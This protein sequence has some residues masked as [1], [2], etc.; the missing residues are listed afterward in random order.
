MN[1]EYQLRAH[2]VSLLAEIYLDH[3]DRERKPEEQRKKPNLEI[4]TSNNDY[5]EDYNSKLAEI[6]QVLI[7]KEEA[8]FEI[9]DGL[10][11]LCNSPCNRQ[12]SKCKVT[13]HD[14]RDEDHYSYREYGFSKDSKYITKELLGIIE[15]YESRTG[16][17]TPRRKRS[18]QLLSNFAL[19]F[20]LV[21]HLNIYFGRQND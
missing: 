14:D 13:L 4:A 1:R 17:K 2:H 12:S 11:S 19:Y 3:L 21:S 20:N 6:A 10:D 5:G 7:K 18:F 16:F 8:T 9:V 15:G